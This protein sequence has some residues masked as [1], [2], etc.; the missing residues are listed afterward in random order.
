[1][2]AFQLSGARSEAL[3]RSAKLAAQELQAADGALQQLTNSLTRA[4]ELAVQLASGTWSAT[5]R[6]IGAAEVGQVLGAMVAS[7][8]TRYAN[9]WLF[10][11][12]ADGAPPFADDGTYLGAVGAAGA[13]RIEIAPGVLQ[14]VSGRADLAIRGD[15][16]GVDVLATVAGLRDALAAND[17]TGIRA[18]LDALDRATTQVA[19]ARAEAGVS[20]DSLTAAEQAGKYAAEDETVRLSQLVDADLAESSIEL[21]RAESAL[22]ATMAASARTFKLSLLDWLR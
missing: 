18:A 11:G 4:R 17:V 10:G 7:L 9:R 14:V 16:G 1:M 2:A 22:E 20:M 6:S 8:N 21:A 13:R 5:E 19:T 3:S 15:G 12:A